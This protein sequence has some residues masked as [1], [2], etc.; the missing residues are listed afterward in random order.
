MR[1]LASLIYILT[2]FVIGFIFVAIALNPD[3]LTTVVPYIQDNVL[4]DAYSRIVLALI[5]ALIVLLSLKYL[6][7]VIFSSRQ[8]KTVTLKLPQ[9]E[10]CITLFALEDMIRKFLDEKK[11]I[12]HI[13]PRINIRKKNIDVTIRSVLIAEI[14]LV[15]LTSDIQERV[16]EKLIG[17]LGSEKEIN[18][19]LDI[20]KISFGGKKVIKE[21]TSEEEPEVPFRNY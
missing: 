10:V 11:E 8:D 13:K 19:R 3:V 12:S 7:T 6:G 5:G 20:K 17:L 14:N 4:A 1:F 16:R 2:S 18:I 15:D 21:D 9:G